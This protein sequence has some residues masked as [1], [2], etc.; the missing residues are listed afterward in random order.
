MMRGQLYVPFPPQGLPHHLL[1]H[2][3]PHPAIRDIVKVVQILRE[4]RDE[5]RGAGV[6]EEPCA[7]TT[8]PCFT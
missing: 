7:Y 8:M 2:G 6:R 1:G 4:G 3:R 5:P